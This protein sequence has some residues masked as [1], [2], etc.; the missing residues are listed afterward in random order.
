MLVLLF[1]AGLVGLRDQPHA[2]LGTAAG[3]GRLHL[4][5]HRTGVDGGGLAGTLVLGWCSLLRSRGIVAL[6]LGDRRVHLVRITMLVLGRAW[7]DGRFR[8]RRGSGSS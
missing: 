8:G 1:G 6:G 2:A 7:C 3:F 5:V 4:G